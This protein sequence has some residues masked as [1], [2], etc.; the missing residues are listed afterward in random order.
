M[1][2]K[3]QP[4]SEADR[5]SFSRE[6]GRKA[7]RKL[8]A[9][10]GKQKSIW[11]GLGMLG[12]IGWVVTIPTLLGIALGFWIDQHFPSRYSWTL[13]LLFIGLVCGCL[14]AWYW[15]ENEHREIR[16]EQQNENKNQNDR[17]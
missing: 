1:D 8:K 2:E 6:V 16:K 10:S 3:R 4:K 7:N 13:M 12:V 9:R 5:I 14:N 11:L 15:V 17:R